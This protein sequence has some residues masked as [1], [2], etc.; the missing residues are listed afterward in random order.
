MIV[1]VAE[2][3]TGTINECAEVVELAYTPS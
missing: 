3:I 2:S 1:L